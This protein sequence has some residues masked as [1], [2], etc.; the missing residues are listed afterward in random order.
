[1]TCSHVGGGDLG[2]SSVSVVGTILPVS[3]ELAKGGEPTGGAVVKEGGSRCEDGLGNSKGGGASSPSGTSDDVSRSPR[4]SRSCLDNSP[5]HTFILRILAP[6]VKPTAAPS[7]LDDTV[8]RLR[9]L[10][11][12][13][14]ALSPPS[15]TILRLRLGA[16]GSGSGTGALS[17]ILSLSS[18]CP[19]SPRERT[20][21]LAW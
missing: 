2:R 8:K 4:V 12:A 13:P 5:S 9:T 14:S 7:S 11:C 16:G 20:L 15:L 18:I 10:T 17:G 6:R 1:M 21:G 19:R 3:T